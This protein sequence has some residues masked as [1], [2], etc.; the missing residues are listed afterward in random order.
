MA[1]SAHTFEL[2]DM[3]M[4]VSERAPA[5][6][7]LRFADTLVPQRPHPWPYSSMGMGTCE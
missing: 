2:S 7:K 1:C 6:T 3:G 5:V 4:K